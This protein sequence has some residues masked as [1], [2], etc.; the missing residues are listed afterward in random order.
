M[1]PAT[2]TSCWF[3]L[4]RSAEEYLFKSSLVNT[5]SQQL[6]KRILCEIEVQLIRC[7]SGVDGGSMGISLFTHREEVLH[8]IDIRVFALIVRSIYRPR[9]SETQKRPRRLGIW[10]TCVFW[11][12]SAGTIEAT[13]YMAWRSTIDLVPNWFSSGQ[14]FRDRLGSVQPWVTIQYMRVEEAN[15]S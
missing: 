13:N 7:T 4:K 2:I 6:M 14:E 1:G 12:R 8:A 3:I 10:L 5:A 9:R 15:R 11:T